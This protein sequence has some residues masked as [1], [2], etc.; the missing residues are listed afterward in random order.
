MHV[1]CLYDFKANKPTEL[2]CSKYDILQ[3]ESQLQEWYYATTVEKK[4]GLIPINYCINI[5]DFP[6]KLKEF[7]EK[8]PNNAQESSLLVKLNSNIVELALETRKKQGYFF[9]NKMI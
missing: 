8:I 5:K 1:I 2:T 3:V 6:I 4:Y 7:Y 9:I